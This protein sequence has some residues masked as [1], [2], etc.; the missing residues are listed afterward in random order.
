MRRSYRPKSPRLDGE[1]GGAAGSRGLVSG[2]E[3]HGAL[4]EAQ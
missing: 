3:G 2:G 4:E 1:G